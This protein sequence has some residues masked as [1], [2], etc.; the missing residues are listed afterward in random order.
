MAA[1]TSDLNTLYMELAPGLEAG[2]DSTITKR[3]VTWL[4]GHS[5]DRANFLLLM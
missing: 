1:V 4:G 2:G 3:P 5:S